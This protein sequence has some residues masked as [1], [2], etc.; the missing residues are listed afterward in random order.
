MTTA[1]KIP[2]DEQSSYAIATAVHRAKVL[3]SRRPLQAGEILPVDGRLHA[4]LD[5]KPVPRGME[6]A[7][8]GKSRIDIPE[9]RDLVK[10]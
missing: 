8:F 4:T 2:L 1:K 3:V 5:D 9:F 7:V 10:K 6:T